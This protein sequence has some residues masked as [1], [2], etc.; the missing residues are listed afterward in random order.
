MVHSILKQAITHEVHIQNWQKSPLF[1][2]HTI[3]CIPVAL[4]I[5]LVDRNDMICQIDTIQSLHNRH[6]VLMVE[7]Q[8][9]SWD[10]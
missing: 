2:L 5:S 3:M 7:T 8:K 9:N 4:G 6:A 10:N 1:K